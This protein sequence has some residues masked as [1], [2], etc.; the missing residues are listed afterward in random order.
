MKFLTSRRRHPLARPILLILTLFVVGAVYVALAPA[1]K[2]SADAEAER[3]ITQGHEL[4]TLNCAS[5][6]GLNGEGT[7]QGPAL[8]GVGAASVDFQ[9]STGRM[10][11]ARPAQQAPRKPTRFSDEEIAALAAYVA[12]LGPGPSIP[13]EDQYS[14]TGL[15]AEEVAEGGEIF[16]TN[17]SACHNY[18]GLGGALPEGRYAPPLTDVEP[19]HIYEAL[20]IGPQ[21]MPVFT[22]E[23]LSDQEVRMV[24]AYLKD[25]DQQPNRGGMDLGG[26]G[27]VGEGLWAWGLGV[28]GLMLIAGWIASKG[29]RAK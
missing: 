19:R 20:R 23:N 14:P 21:Q 25:L 18:A 16:R 26:N 6:H 7:S 4:F 10:P 8:A 29:A 9:V 17:C 13:Q 5:C 28:G 15:S 2:S 11:M 22:Q 3:Q 1:S 27:P 12:S 24:I